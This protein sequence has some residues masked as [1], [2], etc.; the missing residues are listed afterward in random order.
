MRVVI[1]LSLALTASACY[2]GR[3]AYVARANAFQAAMDD[4]YW[5]NAV[6]ERCDGRP[7][8]PSTAYGEGQRVVQC[9]LVAL[10][11]E[12]APAVARFVEVVCH[13][14]DDDQCK[15]AQ[16]RT[17]AARLSERY[18]FA[19]VNGV[20]LTCDAHPEACITMTGLEVAVLRSHNEEVQ[21]RYD[22]RLQQNANAEAATYAA[23]VAQDERDRRRVVDALV[24]ATRPPPTVSCHS[25]SY[26]S[27]TDTTCQQRP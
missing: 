11:L 12:A 24:E 25:T 15:Q 13:G 6:F 4:W 3:R 1:A 5:A 27:T 21:R 7:S 18:P 23:E 9:G 14:V 16:A 2:H 22:A 17:F 20:R 10:E 19:D 26:G 8:A